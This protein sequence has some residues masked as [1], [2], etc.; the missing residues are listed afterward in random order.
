VRVALGLLYSIYLVIAIP[1][2]ADGL[3]AGLPP[4]RQYDTATAMPFD[5]VIVLDGDNRRGRVRAVRRLEEG[6]LPPPVIVLADAGDPWVVNNLA[7]AGVRTDQIT[8]LTGAETTRGQVDVAR[9][10]IASHVW[11]R[12]ALVASRLQA[13]RLSELTRDW[14][15]L[16]SIVAA[17][18][19]DEPPRDGVWALVPS[20]IALR[21]SRD[22]IY[23]HAALMYYRWRGWI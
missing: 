20:Y 3:A 10:I 8:S 7:G 17:P 1:R 5:A 21:V 19:D 2:V 6:E 13:P 22:A 9:R 15:P 11:D 18:V 4:S 23:E 14:R 16:P 12:V